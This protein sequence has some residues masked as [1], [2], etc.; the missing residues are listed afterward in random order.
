VAVIATAKGLALQAQKDGYKPAIVVGVFPDRL[1]F[2]M[3]TD[4]VR[5]RGDGKVEGF[6]RQGTRTLVFDPVQVRKGMV[7]ANRHGFQSTPI[8]EIT[9]D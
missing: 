7:L 6:N 3:A 1:S 5:P 2:L 9:Y 4:E 8:A